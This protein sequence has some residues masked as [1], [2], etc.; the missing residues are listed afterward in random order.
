[1]Y[2]RPLSTW[3]STVFAKLYTRPSSHFN[4]HLG[5]VYTGPNK[6]LHGHKLARFHLAFIRDRQELDKF[7]NGLGPV[8]TGP[9]K[10]LHGQKLARFHLAFT[11]ERW[12]WT[13]FWTAECASL[14]PEKSRS[15]F[16]PARF[17]ICTD[18][19]KHPNRATFCSDSAV[20]A[21]NQMPR[22]V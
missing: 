17:Q 4:E 9:D 2:T 14:G 16:W 22:L 20:M 8:Y 6:Y 21:W 18:L 10:S 5:P 13:N 1:M 7:L 11:R 12:N 3:T 19:C 15:A